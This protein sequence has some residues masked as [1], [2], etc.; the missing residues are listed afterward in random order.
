MLDCLFCKII[1]KEIPAEIF[2]EDEHVLVFPDIHPKAKT[3][4]LIITKKHISSLLAIDES[5]N[6][7]L[8]HL[9]KVTTIIAD[10][11]NIDGYRVQINVGKNGGQEIFH[12]HFHFLSNF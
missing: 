8:G 4:F 11:L 5:D 9:L 2:Y 12:I 10:R 6:F 3:H 1:A 7:I